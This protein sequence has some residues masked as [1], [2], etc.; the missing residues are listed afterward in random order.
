MAAGESESREPLR[1]VHVLLVD[2]EAECLDL[3]TQLLQYLGALVTTCN[4]PQG[5]LRVLQ[6]VRPNALVIGLDPTEE[7]EYWLIRKVRALPA[8]QGGAIAAIALTPLGREVD[9]DRVL[10]EGFQ[11]HLVRPVRLAEL[12]R[13][14]AALARTR[15]FTPRV[16][17]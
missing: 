11:A 1:G 13:A 2:D 3:L 12:S 14:V 17:S 4:S 10:A 5:A 15:P 6:R 7:H 16:A 8:E 9:R